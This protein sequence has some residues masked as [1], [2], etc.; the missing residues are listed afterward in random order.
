MQGLTFPMN[1]ELKV[2]SDIKNEI[3][4]NFTTNDLIQAAGEPMDDDFDYEMD[5]EEAG[6]LKGDFKSQCRQ[7]ISFFGSHFNLSSTLSSTSRS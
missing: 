7:S 2:E 3:E 6:E 1:D 5:E 4:I